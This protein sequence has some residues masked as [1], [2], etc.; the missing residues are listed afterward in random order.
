MIIIIIDLIFYRSR[1]VIVCTDWFSCPAVD[2]LRS[3][4]WSFSQV[5]GGHD[6]CGRGVRIITVRRGGHVRRGGVRSGGVRS[7]HVRSGGVRSGYVRSGG[8]RSCGHVWRGG[9]HDRSGH[10][11]GDAVGRER[12]GV[13]RGHGHRGDRGGEGHD[14]GGLGGRDH[15]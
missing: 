3:A 13:R 11:V 8:V 7:G 2:F 15:G 5:S 12:A 4:V 1:V 14:S 6:A 10:R 9:R